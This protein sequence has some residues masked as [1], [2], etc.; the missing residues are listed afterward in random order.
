MGTNPWVHWLCAGKWYGSNIWDC[1]YASRKAAQGWVW[2]VSA[3]RRLGAILGRSQGLLRSLTLDYYACKPC[4]KYY[5][6]HGTKVQSHIECVKGQRF[7][8][9]FNGFWQFSMIFGSFQWRSMVFVACMIILP[10]PSPGVVVSPLQECTK[11]LF[12]Y[13]Y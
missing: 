3:S 5:R 13:F 7:S 6:I 8:M 12:Y 2:F 4:L 10:Y 1:I 11:F 9:V